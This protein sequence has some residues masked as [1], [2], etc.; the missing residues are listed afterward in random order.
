MCVCVAYSRAPPISL[1]SGFF[2]RGCVAPP[3]GAFG[4]H[5]ARAHQRKPCAAFVVKPTLTGERGVCFRCAFCSCGEETTASSRAALITHPASH[6]AGH[7]ASRRPRLTWRLEV[8]RPFPSL[9]HASLPHCCGDTRAPR[10]H[11][12]RAPPRVPRTPSHVPRTLGAHGGARAHADA[13]ARPLIVVAAS[14]AAVDSSS[15]PP[16]TPRRSPR[17]L[18][19]L[20]PPQPPFIVSLLSPGRCLNSGAAPL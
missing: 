5:N 9:P 1:N 2:L 15:R 19:P 18:R 12:T 10:G 13:R 17:R 3:H 7:H 11:L 14:L 16:P 4:H 6:L 8:P 20:P